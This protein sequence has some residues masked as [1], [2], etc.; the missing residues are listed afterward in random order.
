MRSKQINFFIMPEQLTDLNRYLKENGWLI[1]VNKSNDKNLCFTDDLLSKG[2]KLFV[3]KGL[4]NNIE[5]KYIA[6]QKYYIVNS[7]V[8]P[9][10][11]F[12]PPAFNITEKQMRR[13][14]LYFEPMTYKK[15]E[16]D[17]EKPKQFLDAANALFKWFKQNYKSIKLDN[18]KGFFVS[19]NVGTLINNTGLK[20]ITI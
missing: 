11:E 6:K 1:I 13:G 5:Q 18:Y 14:R 8:S 9:V 3:K 16:N 12:F 4:E 7:S 2:I 20:L 15:G 19:Q 10:I 17:S